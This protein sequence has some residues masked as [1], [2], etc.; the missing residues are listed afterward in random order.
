[1]SNREKH[2]KNRELCIKIYG[3]AHI[4]VFYINNEELCIKIYGIA[5]IIVF[6]INNE[7]F[8]ILFL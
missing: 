6:Y 2:D 7:E 3:I 4:I 8:I 5:H 1:M